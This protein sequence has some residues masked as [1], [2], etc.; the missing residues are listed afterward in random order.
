MADELFASSSLVSLQ[1]AAYV[2]L[3]DAVF[4]RKGLVD[5]IREN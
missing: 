1:S 4:K 5:N 3:A 2:A